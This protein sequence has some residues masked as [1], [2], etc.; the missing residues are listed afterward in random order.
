M[1]PPLDYPALRDP[2]ADRRDKEEE[3]GFVERGEQD[4]FPF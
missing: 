4:P 1:L 2:L 3:Q